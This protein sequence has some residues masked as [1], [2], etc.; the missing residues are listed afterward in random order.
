MP[1]T[2]VCGVEEVDIILPIAMLEPIRMAM[3]WKRRRKRTSRKANLDDVLLLIMSP[4]LGVEG[5]A[6]SRRNVMPEAIRLRKTAVWLVFGVEGQDMSL[7]TVTL[8]LITM[9]NHLEEGKQNLKDARGVEGQ[10]I[11]LP[12]VMLVVIS[13]E[14]LL[15]AAGASGK[16]LLLLRMGP[17]LLAD[18]AAHH[19]VNGVDAMVIP[20]ANAMLLEVLMVPVYLRMMVITEKKKDILTFTKMLRF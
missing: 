3:P 20:N 13:M 6:M 16:T 2:L 8:Q 10:G 18:G 14:I 11:R 19:F 5:P 4:V 9:G 1:E 12:I 7:Q 15:A 17:R